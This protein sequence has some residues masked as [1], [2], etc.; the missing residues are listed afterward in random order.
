[1]NRNFKWA[2]L[3]LG[4]AVFVAAGSVMADAYMKQVTHTGAIEMMGQKVPAKN[5]TTIMWIGTD[6][7][8]SLIG[9]TAAIVCIPGENAVLMINHTLKQYSKMSMDV[10][11]ALDKA[12][13][14]GGMGDNPQA[15]EMMKA[16]LAQSKATVEPTAE[17]K[18]IESW[19]AKK[20]LVTYSMGMATI[21]SDIWATQDI[22]I[23]FKLYQDITG[24]MMRQMPGAEK[25]IEEMK[26]IQGVTVLST[27]SI[28]MMGT[29]MTSE[30]RLIEFA[31]KAAPAGIYA[32]PAGY[33]EVPFSADK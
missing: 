11:S 30:T 3:V 22:K 13:A 12:M 15:K 9:D 31:E 2:A 18:Q 19:Q 26:K 24:R 1:M 29:T 20:Y 27:S 10:D 16:M 17:T 6:R 33:T 21:T 28:Q 7:A 23:D 5:D 32:V 14:A 8:V 4:L 25:L